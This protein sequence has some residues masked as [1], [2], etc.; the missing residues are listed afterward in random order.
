[1]DCT[2]VTSGSVIIDSMIVD[3][4]VVLAIRIHRELDILRDI[5]T[6][7]F[8]FVQATILDIGSRRWRTRP[9]LATS[10]SALYLLLLLVSYLR[11]LLPTSDHFFV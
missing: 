10:L 8:Q 11:P 1:M 7:E 6:D 2:N 5:P 4:T 3:G 9:T